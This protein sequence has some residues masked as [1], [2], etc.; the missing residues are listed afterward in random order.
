MG[1]PSGVVF[2]GR[3]ENA[4]CVR[5]TGRV[6]ASV[7]SGLRRAA[8]EALAG[9]A[10]VERVRVDLSGCEYMDSTFIGLLVGWSKRLGGAVEIERPSRACRAALAELGLLEILSIADSPPPFPEDLQPQENGPG[11][12]ADLLLEAHRHLSETSEENRLRFELVRKI[13]EKRSR[14]S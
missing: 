6:S 14:E 2:F 9:D 13:L 12:S 4:L 7:C 10:T 1:A 3:R 8:A 5:A 11:I